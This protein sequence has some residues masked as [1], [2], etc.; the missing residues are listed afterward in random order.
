MPEA[1]TRHVFVYGTLRRGQVHDI[2]LLRPA[3]RWVGRGA[4]A[5]RLYHIDY[6]PG[7]V[8]GGSGVVVGEVYAID[9]ALERE[10]DR[11]EGIEDVACS[12]YLKR[13]VAVEVAGRRLDCLVYEICAARALGR[14]VIPG[15]DWV[16]R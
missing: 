14:P 15:G 13:S 6:Y 1:A 16:M 2:N 5:G 3:P 9:A 8:L 10:L 11:I 4:V 7:L 12:E